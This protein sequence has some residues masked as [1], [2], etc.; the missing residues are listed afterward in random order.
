MLS[1]REHRFPFLR[2]VRNWNRFSSRTGGTLTEKCCHFFDLMRLILRSEPKRIM[3]SGG[4]DVNH[5][6][7]AYPEDGGTPD[8]LD[9]AYVIVDF[10]NGARCLLELCMFAEASKYQEEVSLVGT[11]GKLEAF[12]PA[13]GVRTDDPSLVNYRQG[14]RHMQ[15]SWDRTDPPPPEESGEVHEE[16][17]GVD[18]RLLEAGNHAGAT[19]EELRLF[20]E[21]AMEG[22]GAEVSLHDGSM[23][24][25][26]GLAAHRSIES[27]APILWKDMLR[28]YEAA[29]QASK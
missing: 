6:D 24:V 2:K 7:E 28:E 1:I 14:I 22:G 18:A 13:H 20:T 5:K 19:Y 4:Q 12:A 15:G 10:D 23:A 21:K 26:M 27:G 11:K 29:M 9:N 25:M 8:I 17:V 3:A 16:H